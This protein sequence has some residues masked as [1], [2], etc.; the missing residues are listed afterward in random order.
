MTEREI[1]AL[2]A[3]LPLMSPAAGFADRV[4][5]RVARARSASPCARSICSASGS[6]PPVARSPS[7][8]ACS[9]WSRARWRAASSGASA[10]RKRWPRSAPGSLRRPGRPRGSRVAGRRVELHRTALVRRAQGAR[11][12]ARDASASPPRSPSLAYLCGVLALRRLLALPTPA[13]GPCERCSRRTALLAL[14]A[15]AG[16]R[17]AFAAPRSGARPV[18]ARPSW[19]TSSGRSSP[20]C[21]GP[22]A[23]PSDSQHPARRRSAGRRRR[24]PRSRSTI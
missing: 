18:R 5:A 11:R 7:R 4:M 24:A 2:L 23:D 10:T 21:A 14:I 3:G 12:P 19:S 1:V 8:P 17:L 15:L 22:A 16:P 9:C 13:G 20:T 6:S